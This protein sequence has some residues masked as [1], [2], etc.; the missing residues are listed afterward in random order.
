MLNLF[1][2]TSPPPHKVGL[3]AINQNDYF[4]SDDWFNASSLGCY[5]FLE[6]KVNI[7]WVEAQL[8]CEEQGGYLAEPYTQLYEEKNDKNCNKLIFRQK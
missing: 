6:G 5:K 3:S 1:W 7:T 4:Y 2:K 8:A